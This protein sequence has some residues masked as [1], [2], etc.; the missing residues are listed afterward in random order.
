MRQKILHGFCAVECT[1][2]QHE[3]VF[4]YEDIKLQNDGNYRIFVKW[5]YPDEKETAKQVWLISAAFDK[6]IVVSTVGYNSNGE[7]VYRQ[8]YPY[9]SEWSYVLP[10]TY[11]EAIIETT[12]EIL[13]K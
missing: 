12:K 8:D 3:W 7:A 6:I 9:G 13:L 1:E 11:A 2:K 4:V 10:D 5:D